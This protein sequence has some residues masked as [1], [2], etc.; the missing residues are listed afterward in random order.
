MPCKLQA[1]KLFFY[2]SPNCALA[3]FT[4]TG[5]NV[6][7]V[8]AECVF[9]DLSIEELIPHIKLHPDDDR[10]GPE[11][12]VK[13]FDAIRASKETNLTSW[14]EGEVSPTENWKLIGSTFITGTLSSP[15]IDFSDN[16]EGGQQELL[17]EVLAD[18]VSPVEAHRSPQV[19][20]SQKK[21]RELI[22]VIATSDHTYFLF[23]SKSLTIFADEKLPTRDKLAKNTAK[24]LKKAVGQLRGAI[25]HLRD[26]KSISSMQGG[27]IKIPNSPGHAIV[28]ISDIS[29][30]HD[31]DE[32]GADLLLEFLKETEHMLHIVDPTEL[33]R[34]IQAS[35]RA[36]MEGDL[37]NAVDAFDVFFQRRF[38]NA[39]KHDIAAIKIVHQFP[40]DENRMG[41]GY[42]PVE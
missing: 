31:S 21:S 11:E 24:H 41:K 15:L 42:V 28:V 19:A 12:A 38:E 18:G 40:S 22:D 20:I 2:K 30:L 7:F 29:L 14:I 5:A 1:I 33:T 34:I 26:G 4:E 27:T 3:I 10:E 9:K 36:V 17:V 35:N 25:R 6:A 32:H 16:D 37:V 13:A 23:E 8:Q 39:I